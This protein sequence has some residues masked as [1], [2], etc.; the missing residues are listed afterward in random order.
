MLLSHFYCP[1]GVPPVTCRIAPHVRS[2]NFVAARAGGPSI[3][4][5]AVA[6]NHRSPWTEATIAAPARRIASPKKIPKGSADG[7]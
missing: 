5:R 1:I 6:S 3:V 7:L 2:L 4:A